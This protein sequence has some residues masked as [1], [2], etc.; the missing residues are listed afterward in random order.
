MMQKHVRHV[1]WFLAL[2]CLLSAKALAANMT[3][4]VTASEPV[5][6]TGTPR[7]AINVGG[8]TRYANF[9]SSAGSGMTFA[10]QVQAGDFD[11]DGIS[12]DDPQIDLNGG[13]VADLVGNPLATLAFTAPNTSNLKI[14]TYTAAFTSTSNPS[15]ISI[16]I[17]KAALNASFSYTIS[18]SNGAGT[19]SG[20]GAITANPQTVSGIDV[21]ALAAGTLSLSVT[22]SNASGTG[23][24]RTA[25]YTPTLSG[26]LDGLPAGAAA[27][28]LRRMRGS[29][30]GPLLRVRRS[31][32]D[33]VR[34]IGSIIDSGNLDTATLTSF[35]GTSSCFVQIWYDQTGNGMD[36]SQAS[37]SAQ[38][39]IINAGT[40]DGFNGLPALYF[41]GAGMGLTTTGLLPVSTAVWSTHLINVLG[42]GGASL[43]RVWA[44]SGNPSVG[45]TLTRDY[46]AGSSSFNN[47]TAI[48]QRIMSFAVPNSGT[49]SMWR[50]GTL[51]AT[52]STAL[53]WTGGNVLVIGN[54]GNLSRA[55]HGHIQTVYLG[56]GSY[57]TADRQTAE[58]WLGSLSGITVP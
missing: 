9:I 22:V 45:A 15:A 21:S 1:F 26:P 5:T 4:T 7:I 49:S 46:Y 16:A 28:S 29:Y 44:L 50:N 25:S 43:G 32:D 6:V 20:S 35:C 56:V 14:Q 47:T 31:S 33:A 19:V 11:P 38:P 58:R 41:D 23:A 12:I 17:S 36:A 27:Y 39:R 48:T 52:T 55:F 42:D 10:Y 51:A 30:T 2:L 53:G 24:A 3:F 34:D 8:V 40:I 57:S 54:I 37:F 18:S 13:V